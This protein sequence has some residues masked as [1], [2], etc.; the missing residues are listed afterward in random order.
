VAFLAFDKNKSHSLMREDVAQMIE[1]MEH[2]LPIDDDLRES[3]YAELF[4]GN[5]ERVDFSSFKDRVSSVPVLESW[6]L[7]LTTIAE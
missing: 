1:A 6:L 2:T 7:E 5:A 3:I 4:Q